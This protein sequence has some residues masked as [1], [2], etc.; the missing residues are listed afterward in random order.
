VFVLRDGRWQ[1]V[2]WQATRLAPAAGEK[3]LSD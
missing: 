1:V 3:R 2:S